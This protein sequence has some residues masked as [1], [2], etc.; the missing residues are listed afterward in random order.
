M[1]LKLSIKM[2]FWFVL[3]DFSKIFIIEQSLKPLMSWTFLI[4]PSL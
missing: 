4:T 3:I 2:V 1:D